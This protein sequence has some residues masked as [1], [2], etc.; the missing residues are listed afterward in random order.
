[1]YWISDPDIELINAVDLE[2]TRRNFI[3]QEEVKRIHLNILVDSG[4]Y[5]MAIDEI[6]Q[7]LDLHLLKKEKCN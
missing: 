2:N 7:Q 5:M 6:I 3:G 4:A 1:M